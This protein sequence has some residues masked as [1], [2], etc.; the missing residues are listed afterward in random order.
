MIHSFPLPVWCYLHINA[1]T[2][3]VAVYQTV[4][5]EGGWQTNVKA[6]TE[7]EYFKLFGAPQFIFAQN[8]YDHIYPNLLS[9]FHNVAGL[10]GSGRAKNFMICAKV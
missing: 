3:S 1:E 2:I 9:E 5:E 10:A 6:L 8:I 7:L 4:F